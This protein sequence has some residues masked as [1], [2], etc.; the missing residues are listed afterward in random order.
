MNF[1]KNIFYNHTETPTD[2]LMSD[3]YIFPSNSIDYKEIDNHWLHFPILLRCHPAEIFL[4]C[5]ANKAASELQTNFLDKIQL[6]SLNYGSNGY[7]TYINSSS[8]TTMITYTFYFVM[9][10]AIGPLS[11]FFNK[12]YPI[13]NYPLLL[14]L[15]KLFDYHGNDSVDI[16]I[17]FNN[18]TKL[19]IRVNYDAHSRGQGKW[20]PWDIV[21]KIKHNGSKDIIVAYV[22]LN[23]HSLYPDPKTY[24]RI[25]GIANDV[26][27]IN[28][29]EFL[30]SDYINLYETNHNID[31]LSIKKCNIDIQKQPS[32]H[33]ITP[34][35]RF[36]LPFFLKKL[37]QQ[38]QTTL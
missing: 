15:A 8:I 7:I 10:G 6:N 31:W 3:D 16:T 37:K 33:S 20:I 11:L 18:L 23:S 25:F 9:N 32:D 21:P 1:L 2:S 36:F 28:G 29:P 30:I 19:P 17:E 13:N 5:E 4:P 26:C 35:E 27:K 12:L 22:A 38:Q 34:F 14:K 24:Y